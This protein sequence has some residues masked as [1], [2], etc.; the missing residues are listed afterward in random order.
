M[1]DDHLSETLR[2]LRNLCS[3]DIRSLYD[4]HS[5]LLPVACWPPE[6]S[7]AIVGVTSREIFSGS[8]AERCLVGIEHKIRLSDRVRALELALRELG[9]LA[10]D[11]IPPQDIEQMSDREIV[12]VIYEIHGTGGALKAAGSTLDWQEASDDQVDEDYQRITALYDL[13]RPHVRHAPPQNPAA[14]RQRLLAPPP[15][16]AGRS[17]SGDACRGRSARS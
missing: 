4:E 3:F 5:S 11:R 10:P 9:A 8:G 17:A 1:S 7:L 12:K 14:G 15:A 13:L 6:A 16:P 2:V